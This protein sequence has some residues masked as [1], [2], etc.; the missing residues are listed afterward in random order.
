MIRR[1]PRSTL[2][3]YTTLFRS[4]LGPGR[5]AGI[6]DR[7]AGARLE[8]SPDEHRR[9]VLDDEAP[10]GEGSPAPRGAAGPDHEPLGRPP[11]ESP[12]EALLR[13]Q[14]RG[15]RLARDAQDVRAERDRW[16]LV[17][18]IGRAHV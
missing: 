3:P 2:F 10:V 18:E 16:A 13:G 5:G 11:G 14:A 1:P 9:L 17:H 6:R 12:G 4:G 8:Q 7:L 15:E